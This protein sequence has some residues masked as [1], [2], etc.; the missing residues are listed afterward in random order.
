VPAQLS[1]TFSPGE[2]K[3]AIFTVTEN[4][5]DVFL[6]NSEHDDVV[7]QKFYKYESKVESV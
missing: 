7:D 3:V 2:T 6:Y 1:Q 5:F 4:I